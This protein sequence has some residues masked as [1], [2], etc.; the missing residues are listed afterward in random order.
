MESFGLE[1]TFKMIESKHQPNTIYTQQKIP[2]VKICGGYKAAVI[3][4]TLTGLAQHSHPSSGAL[5]DVGTDTLP[6]IET[7]LQANSWTG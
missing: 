6:S 5:A 7:L 2:C 1:K 3:K 4:G